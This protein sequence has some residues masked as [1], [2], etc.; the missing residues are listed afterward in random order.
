MSFRN[1]CDDF[2]AI[3][4][5]ESNSCLLESELLETNEEYESKAEN[6]RELWRIMHNAWQN[7]RDENGWVKLGDVGAYIK[8][9]QPDFDLRNYN[10]KKLSGFFELFPNR[11]ETRNAKSSGLEFKLITQSDVK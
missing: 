7:F 8:R 10:M 2:V 9:V 1:A 6:D 4:N 3:E 11:Y 5:L